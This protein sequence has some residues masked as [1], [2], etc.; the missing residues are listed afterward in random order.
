M[1]KVLVLSLRERL[2]GARFLRDVDRLRREADRTNLSATILGEDH[3]GN[4]RMR[5]FGGLAGDLFPMVGAFLLATACSGSSSR[6]L[7]GKDG[8]TEREDTSSILISSPSSE[9]SRSSLS[10]S[11]SSEAKDVAD[12]TSRQALPSSSTA[13][14][15]R[16]QER[17]TIFPLLP[18]DERAHPS[19]RW[20]RLAKG[21]RS[22]LPL[23]N[24]GND[25]DVARLRYFPLFL[26][27]LS[28]LPDVDTHSV[29]IYGCLDP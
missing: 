8:V 14:L 29:G 15:D 18:L 17:L 7:S 28:S 1:I 2:D 4:D 26:V 6:R 9:P 21:S 25:F 11:S 19:R 23:R 22:P 24:D 16:R 5:T 3:M 27:A 10:R 13:W 20:S 12:M